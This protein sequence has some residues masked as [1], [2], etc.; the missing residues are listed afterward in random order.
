VA[1]ELI[2]VRFGLVFN[3]SR[4]LNAVWHWPMFIFMWVEL[5]TIFLVLAL[6]FFAASA[7]HIIVLV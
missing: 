6:A 5:N 3:H 2:T 4:L 1:N 7:A